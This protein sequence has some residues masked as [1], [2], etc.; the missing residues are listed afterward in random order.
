MRC[1]KNRFLNRWFVGGMAGLPTEEPVPGGTNQRNLHRQEAT[2]VCTDP[3]KDDQA[4]RGRFVSV[5]IPAF[6]EEENL[7]HLY[8]RVCSVLGS[9]GWNFEFI[10]VDD[11]SKDRTLAVIKEL[12]LRD[13]RVHHISFTRNFG[14]QAALL[15]GMAHSRGDVVVSIDS[16]LQ[17]P[18]ELIP[19]MLDLWLE[20]YE[21]VHTVKRS[22]VSAGLLRRVISRAFYRLF[23]ML[24]GVR[25]AFGQSDFRLLDARVVRELSRLPEYHKFLRGLVS[26]M[27][28]RQASLEYDVA[29][30]L[31]GRPTYTLSRRLGFHVDAILSFSIIPLRLFTI[32]GLLVC[33]PAGLYGLLALTLGLYGFLTGYSTWIVPGW[34]SLAIFVTFLGG[35]Q[36]IGI[37]IL[38]EYLGRV[39]EQIKGR[40]AYLV[41]DTSLMVNDEAND[42]SDLARVGTH[43]TAVHLTDT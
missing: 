30:R 35:I 4:S 10:V 38:G 6:N 20:G 43:H 18:P 34:A 36:L 8:Q 14:H 33:V 23:G 1:K 27:G 9:G 17:H 19:R 28:F 15:A 24:S 41:R 39:F 31:N 3:G 40:P 42:L 16:D 13:P 7:P 21:V 12:Q 32:F 11:G 25:V 5:V 22:D 2:Q 37:G 29:P 26:W